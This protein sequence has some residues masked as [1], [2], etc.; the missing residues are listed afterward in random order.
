MLSTAFSKPPIEV[1]PLPRK[2]L[3]TLYQ[4]AALPSLF[5]IA[6]CGKKAPPG[7]LINL[8]GLSGLNRQPALRV[9]LRQRFWVPSARSTRFSPPTLL[10]SVSPLYDPSSA[11]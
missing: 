10:G 11:E 6:P 8:I 1:T 9:S 7:L 4:V 5:E 2:T 3:Q